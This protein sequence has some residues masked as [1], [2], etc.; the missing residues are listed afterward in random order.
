V[1]DVGYDIEIRP[2]D[3]PDHS[4]RRLQLTRGNAAPMASFDAFIFT[5][6]RYP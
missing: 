2:H 4:L 3:E 6:F 1:G 5:S